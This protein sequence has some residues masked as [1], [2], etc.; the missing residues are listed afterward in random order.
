MHCSLIRGLCGKCLFIQPWGLKPSIAV[1]YPGVSADSFAEQLGFVGDSRRRIS[2]W[3]ALR[4]TGRREGVEQALLKSE[5]YNNVVPS[6]L[7]EH[8]VLLDSS[9]TIV[10]V[11]EASKRFAR[12]NA[13]R[14]FENASPNRTNC[15]V[16]KKAKS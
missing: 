7:T 4:A 13:A 15:N 9:G 6:P 2:A 16:E 5:M 11:N 12:E 1:R 3:L 10:T 14:R 8:I